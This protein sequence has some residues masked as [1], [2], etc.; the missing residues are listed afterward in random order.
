MKDKQERRPIHFAAAC[1]GSGPLEYL[2]SKYENPR[3]RVLFVF[4]VNV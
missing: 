1:E 2:L 3:Q 4:A